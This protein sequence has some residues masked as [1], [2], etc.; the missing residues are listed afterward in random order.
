MKKIIF[1]ILVFCCFN[2]GQAAL[3]ED[4]LEATYARMLQNTQTTKTVS[5]CTNFLTK[6]CT[7][8]LY[9]AFP[10]ANSK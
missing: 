9:Q 1:I 2:L 3:C 10:Q 5:D 4:I 7:I 8:L 6:N